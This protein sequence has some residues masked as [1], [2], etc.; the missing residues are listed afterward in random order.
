MVQLFDAEIIISGVLFIVSIVFGIWTSKLGSPLNKV[1]FT[2]HKLASVAAV[3][4]IVIEISTL[5]K[6]LT[7]GL[8]ELCLMIFAGSSIVVSIV[9]GVILSLDKPVDKQV[10]NIHWAASV[11]SIITSFA[12]VYI[13][14]FWILSL[15]NL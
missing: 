14:K 7:P 8:L 3:V 6:E 4:F 13:L 11:L 2:V 1:V 15:S 5:L 12:A 10:L 9:T